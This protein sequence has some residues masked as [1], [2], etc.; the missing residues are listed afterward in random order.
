MAL[1]ANDVGLQGDLI[2]QITASRRYL[3]RAEGRALV[4]SWKSSGQSPAAFCRASGMAAWKLAYWRSVTET[5]SSVGVGFVELAA[6]RHGRGLEL[7]LRGGL[8]IAIEAGFD[9]V[10]LRAVV[11]ALA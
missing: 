9:P 10:V 6:D 5:C 11:E 1:P 2:V 7:H 4:D 8:R 3:T